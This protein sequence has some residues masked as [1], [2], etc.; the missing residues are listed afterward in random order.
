MLDDRIVIKGNREGLVAIIKF[1]AFKDFQD[2]LEV[3]LERL[4]KGKKFYKGA[5]IT[6]KTELKYIDER[7]VRLL[8][9]SLFDEVGIKECIF[10]DIDEKDIKIFSGIYEGRTKFIRKT[11]RGGQRVDY[12]GNIVIVGDIN[13]GS[14]VYA[15]GNIIVLGRIRGQVHAGI[16]GNTKAIIAAFSLEPELLQIGDIITVS[17]E[18]DDKPRYP[19]VAKIKDGVIMVEP[20]LPNKFA[21][22]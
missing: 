8:K 15:W 5:T 14:E 19:E 17:P 2:M 9:H 4:N 12:N 22:K 1:T 20:Y 16:N 18:G 13:S 6:I 10:K 7:E 11:I 3:F 21:Y